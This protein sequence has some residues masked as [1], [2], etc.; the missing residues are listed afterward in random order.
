MRYAGDALITAIIK[1]LGTTS[2]IEYPV[3]TTVPIYGTVPN[4]AV[5]PYIAIE[6]SSMSEFNVNKTSVNQ[7]HITNIDIVTRFAVGRGGFGACNDI[8]NQ[9]TTIIRSIGNYLDLSAEN[10]KVYIQQVNDT[11]PLREDARDATYYRYIIR[12]ETVIQEVT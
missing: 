3:G 8:A 7:S 6:P 1:L 11:T 5:F 2:T 4:D 9:V 10:F 12:L